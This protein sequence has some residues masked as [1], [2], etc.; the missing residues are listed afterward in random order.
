MKA[1]LLFLGHLTFAGEGN[2]AAQI[3]LAP[4]LVLHN[5][6]P[7]PLDLTL[8]P[9]W[10]GPKTLH[11]GPTNQVALLHLEYANLE[12]L[13]LL[14]EGYQQTQA[15]PA[16]SLTIKQGDEVTT[17]GG[18]I[19]KAQGASGGG[20]SVA[21]NG[22]SPQ[23]HPPGAAQS[24]SMSLTLYEVGPGRSTVDV[25]LRHTIDPGTGTHILRVACPLW[26]YNCTGLPI[27]LR[28][29]SQVL[30]V[31]GA[32]PDEGLAAADDQVP[33][34]WVPPLLLP[35]HDDA[36]PLGLPRS[37]SGSP[38]LRG[39]PQQS[40]AGRDLSAASV[41]HGAG[42]GLRGVVAGRG[43]GIS[44]TFSDT[45][46]SARSALP[47][48]ALSA[49]GSLPPPS[50]ARSSATG[51]MLSL[52]RSA[53]VAD[54]PGLQ[55]ILESK[56]EAQPSPGG[57]LGMQRAASRAR[58]IADSMDTAPT[59]ERPTQWPSMAQGLS[60]GGPG[61]TRLHLQVR[62]AA[63]KAPIGKSYWSAFLDI[64]ASSGGVAVTSLPLPSPATA[65]AATLG[66]AHRGAQPVVVTASS[67]Q[68]ADGALALC[69]APRY[70]LRNLLD[71]PI[72]Y[73]QQGTGGERE[74]VPGAV[75]AVRWTDAGLPPRLCV[76]VQEAGWMWSGGFLL[77]V[78][79]DLF[80]KIRH[81]DRGITML[82][83]VDVAI[84]DAGI[85]HVTLS[86][87]PSGFAPYR[88]ENCSLETLNARQRGVSEQQDVLRPYCSLNYAWDEP[89]LPHAL[90][91]ELPGSRH[92]GTF[93]LDQVSESRNPLARVIYHFAS[94]LVL[95]LNCFLSICAFCRLVRMSCY[96]CTPDAASQSGACEWLSEPKAPRE[97][98]L[99]WIPRATP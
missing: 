83:R 27:A 51:S 91:L 5:A 28:S 40:P 49:R 75:C 31:S 23:K 55:E 87:N 2:M 41:L 26:V 68:E 47:G 60:T 39:T 43:W 61:S 10:T 67:V 82:V 56:E 89:T 77:D 34:S 14:P 24:T 85:I 4:P 17:H 71:A 80:V 20:T 18:S 95:R 92:V 81:R 93:N 72:Q 12:S 59:F 30:E 48:G 22:G 50:A 8:R 37:V 44:K 45:L 73:K 54:A 19:W 46:P 96:R 70:V 98:S 57:V 33:D 69:I 36:E 64:D 62:A 25:S 84:T 9:K 76:R 32:G 99:Y 11:L 97:Y 66:A 13:M 16:N 78:P 94:N 88:I 6:L 29:T 79:G 42:S 58:G 65:A 7:V 86:H 35:A 1:N 3:I 74:L 63:T 53:S 52:G 38:I 90:V 15:I 21:P